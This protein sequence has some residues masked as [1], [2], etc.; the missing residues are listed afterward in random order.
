MPL[1]HKVDPDK[2]RLCVIS[3]G[4]GSNRF[5]LSSSS[6]ATQQAFGVSHMVESKTPSG[7]VCTLIQIS[8]I[9]KE[10]QEI[11]ERHIIQVPV[12]VDSSDYLWQ[13]KPIV[14]PTIKK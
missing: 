4:M 3:F 12:V 5:S 9:K 7:E 2:V 1:S 13:N 10:Y 11:K 6:S 14:F 8:Y